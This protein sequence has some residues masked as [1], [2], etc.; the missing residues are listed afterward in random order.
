LQIVVFVPHGVRSAKLR[1]PQDTKLP[2]GDAAI[3]SPEVVLC[4]PRPG[5]W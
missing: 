3:V 2:H 4:V 1:A 5:E